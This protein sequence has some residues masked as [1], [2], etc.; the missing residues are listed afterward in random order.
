MAEQTPTNN[1]GP[2]RQ[3]LK[4][5]IALAGAC[6]LIL[7]A[8]MA[9]RQAD[10]GGG[11]RIVLVG[12]D[13]LTWDVLDPL[14]DEGKL[15]N[16]Q[17]LIDR[18]AA[19]ELKT[20][21]ST[22]IS[23]SI[24]NTILTGKHPKQHGIKG[25]FTTKGFPVNSS[26]RKTKYLP[27]ILGQQ[28]VK[29]AS[30]GF[31]ATWP[32][33][34]I[35]GYIVSDLASYGRFKDSSDR[36][37]QTVSDYTYMKKLNKVT[38]PEDL[39][40][41]ILPVMKAPGQIPRQTYQTV[42]T[43]DDDEWKKFD[44]IDRLSRDNDKSLL[45]FSIVTDL[46]FHNAGMEIIKRHN[47]EAYMV[48]FQGPDIIEHF[49][50]QYMDPEGFPHVTPEA[51]KKYGKVIENYYALMDRLLGEII[52][53]A[54]NAALIIVC[55]DHGM[56]KVRFWGQ[57]GLHSGEHRIS[58]PPGVIIMA[59][60]GVKATNN[61]RITGP[62]VYDVTPTLLYL[63]GL[64][65]AKDMHGKIFMGVVDKDFQNQ[66]PVRLIPTYDKEIKQKPEVVSPVDDKIKD[67]LRA[68]GYID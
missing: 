17:A 56:Q 57:D 37:N 48:Y 18:G 12:M 19:A 22:Y 27:Q 68:I 40:D 53:A 38:W 55:S 7:G 43:M 36:A 6:A 65:I 54:A 60:P 29:T 1:T 14:L 5:V 31:M 34:Q 44:A 33:E 50:W 46:N 3:K 11:P 42:L 26:H 32:A 39:V 64:P 63:A 59:G 62:V 15:P 52:D 21:R 45:K 13:A 66:N 4:A 61:K 8:Y 24:W 41:Q 25:F 51:A 47:P 2:G 49:F 20:M 35:N 23:A 58:K 30:V 16:F 67:R 28:G 9:W 10:P